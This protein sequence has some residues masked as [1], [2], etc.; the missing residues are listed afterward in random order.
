MRYIKLFENYNFEEK[1]GNPKWVLLKK[2]V[3]IIL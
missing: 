3:Q 1:I 2:I